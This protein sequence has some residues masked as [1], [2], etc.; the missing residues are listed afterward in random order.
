MRIKELIHKANLLS[1]DSVF[2][3]IKSYL[4]LENVPFPDY[5]GD[6]PWYKNT[7]S[8]IKAYPVRIWLYY[9]NSSFTVLYFNFIEDRI[10]QMWN[11]FKCRY[12]KKH[13]T[14]VVYTGLEPGFHDKDKIMLYSCFTLLVE[15]V[16]KDLTFGQLDRNR[17]E[18]LKQLKKYDSVRYPEFIEVEELYLWWK[19]LRPRRERIYNERYNERSNEVTDDDLFIKKTYGLDNS[20]MNI[21]KLGAIYDNEDTENLIRLAKIRTKLWT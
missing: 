9:L 3:R 4:L 5:S 15:Y 20:K 18:G 16:E 12:V 7:L 1:Q 13:I 19:D 6:N 8:E 2:P 11:W 21:Y 17:E 14:H 10:E